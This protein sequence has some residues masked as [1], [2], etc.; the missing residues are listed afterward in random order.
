MKLLERATAK[1]QG[2]IFLNLQLLNSEADFFDALTDELSKLSWWKS[3][4]TKGGAYFDWLKKFRSIKISGPVDVEFSVDF[5]K[6]ESN[7]YREF[8][9]VLKHDEPTVI[10]FDEVTDLLDAIMK[11]ENGRARAERF[12][13]GLRSFR[14]QSGSKIKWIFISSV[15]IENFMSRHNLSA[16]VNDFATY[17][18]LAFSPDT[19]AT[20][21]RALE[22][23]QDMKLTDVIRNKM[24]AKIGHL[25]PFFIQLLFAK[26][27]QLHKINESP[28]DEDLVDVAYRNILND[29]ELN[30]WIERLNEQYGEQKSIAHAV[31]KSLCHK[32]Q[33][34]HRADI[35]QGL[36]VPGSTEAE[37]STAL[38]DVLFM[39]KNDGYLDVKEG[40]YAFRSPLLRD[41]WYNRYVN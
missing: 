22:A 31:L 33:G 36:S 14:Q 8:N 11:K 13:Q 32:P 12:L 26:M 40:N 28:I 2:A 17:E 15:G 30:T 1:K 29:A 35:L 25:L 4:L 18:L 6:S 7:I 41:F 38:G 16:T 21:I 19:A 3:K 20:M 27:Q 24:L 23:G 9:S 34:L 39:L 10:L 5:D 37:I